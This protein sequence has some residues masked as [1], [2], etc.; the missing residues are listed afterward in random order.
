MLLRVA[1]PLNRLRLVNRFED[2]LSGGYGSRQQYR[3]TR[4]P[5][6]HVNESPAARTQRLKE[7]D[8]ERRARSKKLMEEMEQSEERR[9]MEEV[10]EKEKR[11]WEREQGEWN[12]RGVRR[13]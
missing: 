7:E 8:E 10:Q 11:E 3:Q 6:S 4:Q 9:K 1:R 13:N 2:I 12:P 5:R